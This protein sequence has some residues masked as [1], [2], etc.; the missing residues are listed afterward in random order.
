MG[1]HWH[2]YKVNMSLFRPVMMQV[3]NTTTRLGLTTAS[4]PPQWQESSCARLC[5]SRAV[6]NRHLKTAALV[7]TAV[8][9]A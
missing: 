7:K 3:M 8:P 2:C 5:L 6:I 4:A 9:P 1:C